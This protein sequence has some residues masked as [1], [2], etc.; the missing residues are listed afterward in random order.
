[1]ALKTDI[2]GMVH[3][4][5]D[6]FVVGRE[7]IRQFAHAVKAEDP[8]THDEAA[9]AELG[10]EALVAPPTFMTILAVMIQ[11]HF[12]QHVDIGMET[13][14][15][16]QVDQKFKF[17][18]PVKAG[19]RLTGTMYIETVDERFGADIV[20]T[21]NVCTDEDGEIVMEAFTTLMGHEGDNSISAKWD[22]E[23][24]QVIRT[25]VSTNGQSAD[26]AD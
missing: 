13:M 19:D 2:R 26:K 24:G 14:Q 16:V 11:R 23:T 17:H 20:T 9:A 4:Y 6:V 22:P 1:M 7:Q 10:H 21:R 8:A 3:K 25:A 18:R 15:I 12:F 5:P